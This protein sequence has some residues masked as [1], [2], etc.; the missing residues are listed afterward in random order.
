MGDWPHTAPPEADPV[1]SAALAA[2][3]AGDASDADLAAEAAARSGAIEAHRSD[4]TDVHGFA[5]TDDVPRRGA[6]NGID[7]LVRLIPEAGTE[8]TAIVVKSPDAEWRSNDDQFDIYGG[9]QVLFVMKEGAGSPAELVRMRIAS[10]GSIG[11]GGNV[12]VATGLNATFPYG[13]AAVWIDPSHDVVGLKIEN[14]LDGT[15]DALQVFNN[16]DLKAQ[17]TAAGDLKV[18]EGE[19]G[20]VVI[21]QANGVAAVLL[22]NAGDAAIWREPGLLA[23]NATNGYKFHDGYIELDEMATPSNPAA[24]NVRIYSKD[25]GAGKTQIVARWSTGTETVIATQP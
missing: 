21:G 10:D 13:G 14:S 5:N 1:A 16:G 2:H 23:F 6:V 15:A 20:Q 24:D 7:G 17:L 3:A 11:I 18:R 12:H 19:V 4:K 8:Q 22:S 25:S 9:E